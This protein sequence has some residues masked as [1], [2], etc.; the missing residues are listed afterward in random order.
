MPPAPL[1]APVNVVLEP[2]AVYVICSLPINIVPV[3]SKPDVLLTVNS[4]L[5]YL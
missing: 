5:H 1:V 4:L 2:I 3:E